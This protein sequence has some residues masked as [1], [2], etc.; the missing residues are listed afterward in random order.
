MSQS[1]EILNSRIALVTKSGKYCLGIK[2]TLKTLRAGHGLLVLI[3]SNCPTLR[4]IEIE[5]MAHLA[6]TPVEVYPGSTRE[7]G[8]ACGKLFN[9]C[10]MCITN[11]GDADLSDLTQ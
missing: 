9:A 11:A 6:D 7:L 8:T 3:A 1:L 2:E 4:K 10:C 5:Y